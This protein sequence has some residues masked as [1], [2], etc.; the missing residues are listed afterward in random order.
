MD[1]STRGTY[2]GG[3]RAVAFKG[4]F[5]DGMWTILGV[6]LRE[7]FLQLVRQG[8]PEARKTVPS[9]ENIGATGQPPKIS[10]KNDIYKKHL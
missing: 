4:L 10:Y 8:V 7:A 2:A 1:I 5:E 6:Q 3:F 9:H